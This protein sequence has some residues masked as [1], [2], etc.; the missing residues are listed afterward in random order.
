[1]DTAFADNAFD[2]F[3]RQRAR[4]E[5]GTIRDAVAKVTETLDLYSQT[6]LQLL[7]CE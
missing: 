3:A 5:N 2:D 1:M 4:N 6:I 7:V